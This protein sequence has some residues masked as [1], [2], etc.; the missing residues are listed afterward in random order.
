M[1][2]RVRPAHVDSDRAHEQ[3]WPFGHTYSSLG[4]K[5]RLLQSHLL[6]TRAAVVGKPGSGAWETGADRL[7][8]DGVSLTM[9][10]PALQA[11]PTEND[12]R[13][14]GQSFACAGQA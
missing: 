4:S 3:G 12:R 7:H 8:R 11:F 6:Q 1:P 13:V 9:K 10:T 2:H 14:S 5:W